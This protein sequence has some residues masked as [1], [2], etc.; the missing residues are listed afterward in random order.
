MIVKAVNNNVIFKLDDSIV[1]NTYSK[2]HKCPY[3]DME[4]YDRVWKSELTKHLIENHNDNIKLIRVL[5]DS[6]N[7]VIYDR[8]FYNTMMKEV[9]NKL[10]KISIKGNKNE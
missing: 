1:V 5:Y 8:K 9:E 6:Y 4:F 7:F 3:C 2:L 10:N